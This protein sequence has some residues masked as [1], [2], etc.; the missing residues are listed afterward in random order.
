MERGNTILLAADAQTLY[1][2]FPTC[3]LDSLTSNFD[4]ESSGVGSGI[5]PSPF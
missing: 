5:V 3:P 2:R 1:L 4:G